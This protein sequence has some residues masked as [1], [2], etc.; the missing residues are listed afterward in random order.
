M[1]ALFTHKLARKDFL[2]S[3]GIWMALEMISFVFLP[4][5]GLVEPNSNLQSWFYATFPLGITGALLIGF[6]SGFIAVSNRYGTRLVKALKTLLGE[7]ISLI[8]IVGIAFPLL[9]GCMELF[10]GIFK[11]L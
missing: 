4:A 6:G 8:G 5:L 10:A 2:T 9:V 3:L 1:T 11:N 7:I